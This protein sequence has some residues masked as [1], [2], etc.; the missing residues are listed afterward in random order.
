VA[1]I[2]NLAKDD[3]ERL[4]TPITG[5]LD[6]ILDQKLARGREPQRDSPPIERACPVRAGA[7]T[8]QIRD[9]L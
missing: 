5:A 3:G 9:R 8:A 1:Q 7:C 6:S 4:N 2:P